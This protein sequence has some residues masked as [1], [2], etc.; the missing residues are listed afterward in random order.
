[1]ALVNIPSSSEIYIEV[2]GRRVAA[3]QGYKVKAARESQLVQAFGSPAPVGMVAGRTQYA[4]EL[5]RVLLSNWDTADYM[6]FYALSD[7][8]VVV[9]KPDR[10]ILFTG[11]QWTAISE[12]AALGQPVLE[13]VSLVAANRLEV[14]G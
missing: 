4:V 12:N 13:Q 11:C 6:D 7:F 2:Q 8:T 9:V 3:A 1:M 14:R 5:S 10:R